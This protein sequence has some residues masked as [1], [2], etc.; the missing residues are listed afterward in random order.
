MAMYSSPESARYGSLIGDYPGNPKRYLIIVIGVIALFMGLTGWAFDSQWDTSSR[1]IL[2]FFGVVMFV[3]FYLKYRGAHARL[4]EQGFVFSRA[5]KETSG[6]W[7]DIA[8][9][10]R[11]AKQWYL[12]GLIPI[13]GTVSY[14]YTVYLRNGDKADILSDYYS[15]MEQLVESA[16]RKWRQATASNPNL[17]SS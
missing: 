1:W 17:P 13:P 11:Q 15:N 9:I 14:N 4:F 2:T 5:G 7:E 16:Q 12:F 8:K 6:R 3:A 10:T